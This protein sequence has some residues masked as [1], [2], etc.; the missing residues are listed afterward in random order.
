MEDRYDTSSR[1]KM[2]VLR[3]TGH[4]GRLATRRSPGHFQIS[5]TAGESAEC[6]I[7]RR[8]GAALYQCMAEPYRFPR[9]K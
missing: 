7:C 6:L 1:Y 8:C 9:A 4:R 3:L 2:P 5:Q